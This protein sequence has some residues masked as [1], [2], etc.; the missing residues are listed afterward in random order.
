M[1]KIKCSNECQNCPYV[2]QCLHRIK[3]S[4]KYKDCAVANFHLD[5]EKRNLRKKRDKKN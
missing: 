3:I 1:G 5:K 4:G 2:N